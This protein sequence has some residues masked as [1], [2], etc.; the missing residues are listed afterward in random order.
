MTRTPPPPRWYRPP[1]T[2]YALHRLA[3]CFGGERRQRLARYGD[4]SLA[5]TL[6]DHRGR[7]DFYLKTPVTGTHLKHL[8]GMKSQRLPK[9]L[10]NHQPAGGIN[11]CFHAIKLP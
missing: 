4:N 2:P 5:T 1:S 8:T 3:N 11:G 9:R 10:G 7:R 6:Q